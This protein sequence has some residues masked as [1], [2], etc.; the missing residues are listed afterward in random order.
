MQKD[1]K[2][3]ELVYGEARIIASKVGTTPAYVR[4]A[5]SRYRSGKRIYGSKAK[6]IIKA[7]NRLKT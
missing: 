7:F 4:N 5:L 2:N 6:K 3:I 1:T